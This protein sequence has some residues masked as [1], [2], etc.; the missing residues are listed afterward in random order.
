MTSG[1]KELTPSYMPIAANFQS[2]VAAGV[3]RAWVDLA[4]A[5]GVSRKVL[6]KLSH[7]DQNTLQDQDNRIQLKTLVEL[8][9]NAKELCQEPALALHFGEIVNCEEYSI[10]SMISRTCATV[11]DALVQRNRYGRLIAEIECDHPDRFLLEHTNNGVWLIDTRK[12]PNQIP[13]LT[14]SLFAVIACGSRQMGDKPMLLAAHFTHAEPAYRAEY[15]RIFQVSLTFG[16]D[17]NAL[18]MD[19]AWLEQRLAS[20]PNYVFGILSKY[21]DA[22]LKKLNDSKTVRGRVES[23]LIPILHTGNTSMNSIAGNMG[24]SRQTLYRKLKTEGVTYKEVL[25]GLRH[26]LA[27]H[28]IKEQ[29]VSV[30]E[31]AYLVGFSEPA[32]F[33]RAFKRWTG[34][35]PHLL[36]HSK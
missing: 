10:V 12:N 36:R 17:R 5:K 22:L 14:E 28:Y 29:R 21:A 35:R 32:A 30:S 34:S 18:L 3:V 13:E 15:D 16:S 31:T 23:L 7:L 27:M 20:A 33:S 11:A 6:L 26:Q 8:I 9:R 24:V 25:D 19:A 1:N 4:V 2:T